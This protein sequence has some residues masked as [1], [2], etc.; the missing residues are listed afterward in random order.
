MAGASDAQDLQSGIVTRVN[1]VEGRSQLYDLPDVVLPN[2]Y[3]DPEDAFRNPGNRTAITQAH[4]SIGEVDGRRPVTLGMH[5]YNPVLQMMDSNGRSF[6]T[7]T[8]A[9]IEGFETREQ[10]TI[11]TTAA[12]CLEVRDPNTGEHIRFRQPEEIAFAGSY[13][14][15]ERHIQTFKMNAD[16]IWVNPLYLENENADIVYKDKHGY[17]LDNI[18]EADTALVFTPQITPQEVIPVKVLPSNYRTSLEISE[19]ISDAQ[20]QGAKIMFAVAGHSSDKPYLTVD[21]HSLALYG[22]YDGMNTQADIVP[23]ASGGPMFLIDQ[24]TAE[25]KEDSTTHQPLMF[26]VNSTV[27][28]KTDQARHSYYNIDTLHDVPF[29]KEEGRESDLYCVQSGEVLV[30]GLN[31]RVSPDVD[32]QLLA[33]DRYHPQ[34]QLGKGELFNVHGDTINHLGQAWALVTTEFGRTGYISANPK[35]VSIDQKS[36]FKLK[37]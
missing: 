14:D 7:A 15:E 30:D 9:T 37:F 5:Q 8:I 12:H 2:F 24:K 26:A 21:E 22:D 11:I 31:I 13:L 32:A 16:E 1:G 27:I 3:S 17:F 10:G 20:D 36:C 33:P 25:I 18:V 29:L 35:Y 28:N 23:G 19:K 6:C 4:D 34:S